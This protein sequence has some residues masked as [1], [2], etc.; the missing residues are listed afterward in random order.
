MKGEQASEAYSPDDSTV[1]RVE[2]EGRKR[3]EGRGNLAPTI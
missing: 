1:N 2:G 3:M